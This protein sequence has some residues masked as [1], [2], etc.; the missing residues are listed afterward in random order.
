MI[1]GCIDGCIDGFSR[2]IIYIQCADNNQ[3]ETVVDY[4]IDGVDRLGLPVRV[5]ADQ[6]CGNYR[7]EVINYNYNYFSLK[8]PN[9]NFNY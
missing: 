3:A 9:C 4:F 7:S 2:R 5:R 8:M 6:C 1:H